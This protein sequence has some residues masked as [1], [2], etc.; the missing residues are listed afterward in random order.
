MKEIIIS[1]KVIEIIQGTLEGFGYGQQ[2][3]SPSDTAKRKQKI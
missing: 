3:I 2:P 1:E